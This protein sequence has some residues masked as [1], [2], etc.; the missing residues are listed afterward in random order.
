MNPGKKDPEKNRY[1]ILDD[2]VHVQINHGYTILIDKQDIDILDNYICYHSK[3][4]KSDKILFK[5]HGACICLNRYIYSRIG[6][7]PKNHIVRYKNNNPFDN[8]RENLYVSSRSRV[9]HTE[10]TYVNKSTG[11]RGLYLIRNNGGYAARIKQNG[12]TY[13]KYFTMKN[14][15]NAIRWL[16]KMRRDILNKVI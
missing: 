1:T 3:S 15:Y 16:E 2:I 6:E 14:K 5:Q 11:I 12:K 8:R 13:N 4:G 10:S 9:S 7:I